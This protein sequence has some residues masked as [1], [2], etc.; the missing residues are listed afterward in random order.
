MTRPFTAYRDE[1]AMVAEAVPLFTWA[2]EQA[3]AVAA[4]KERIVEERARLATV[5]ETVEESEEWK[6]VDDLKE[7]LKE[8]KKAAV[9]HD[10]D[11]NDL[12]E[13]LADARKDLAKVSSFKKQREI[14]KGVTALETVCLETKDRL[15]TGLAA[16]KV[17]TVVEESVLDKTVRQ[18]RDSLARAAGPGGSVTI[19]GGAGDPVTIKGK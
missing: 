18:T 16:G 19:T 6:V 10:S 14:K 1:P 2:R 3:D 5:T 7:K 11:V 9:E 12:A 15:A 4:T 8:A 17:P 13:Q